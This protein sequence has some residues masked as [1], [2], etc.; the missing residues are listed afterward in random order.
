MKGFISL[1]FAI[2]VLFLFSGCSV[3][4]GY[5][6]SADG[7]ENFDTVE[8][9]FEL[10]SCLLP[11]DDFLEQ[12][13]TIDISYHARQKYKTKLGLTS[14]ESTLVSATYTAETYSEAKSYCLN[15]MTLNYDVVIE[16][17][18]YVFIDNYELATNPLDNYTSKFPQWTNML[19]YNDEKCELVFL[20]FYDGKYSN[21]DAEEVCA[22][23]GD[24]LDEHFAELHDFS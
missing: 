21:D 24:F 1:S 22:N 8:G 3:F 14:K 17:N 16:Y 2:L 23:W 18:G 11:S 10:N 4:E 19:A 5:T 6:L 9:E 12:F 7:I 15:K 20:G 13:D